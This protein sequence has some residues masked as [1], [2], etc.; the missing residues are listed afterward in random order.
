MPASPL[1]ICAVLLV[2]LLTAAPAAEPVPPDHAA[3]MAA[4]RKLFQEK[5]RP[6]L[7]A[8]CLKCHGGEKVRSGLNLSSRELL[9]KGGDNGPAVT[10]GKGQASRLVKLVA[11]QEEPHMPPKTPAPKEA[12][13]LLAK[14][15][16]LGAAYDKPLIESAPAG[17]RPLTVT[18][19]DRQYWAYR[20]LREPTP[21]PVT[22]AAWVRNPIDRF[23]LAR[24]EA[25]GIP[26]ARDADKRTLIRRVYFDLIGLPPTP[27]EVKAFVRDA[28]PN[29]YEKVV[30]Q[31]LASPRFG[32]RWARHWLD[33]ARY[34]E[35]HGFEHDYYRPYAYHYRDFVI[36]A[37]NADM[38]YDQ[39]M[40]WQIAGDELAPDDTLALAAT[41][42]LGA[43]VYPT[44]ITT[45]EAERVRYDA[46]DDMLATTGYAMLGLTVGCARCHDHKY[47]PIPTRD[48]YRMLS[49]F[50]TT[51]RSE[52]EV[53][54]GT[55]A[56]KKTQADFEAKLKPLT[57]ELKRYEKTALP[58]QLAAWVAEQKSKGAKLPKPSEANAALGLKALGDGKKTL[59]KLPKLQRDQLLKW[60]APQDAGWKSRDARIK[61]LEKQRPPSTKTKIQATTE[62][63][64]PMRHH[65]ALPSIPDFYP[66]TYFL[67]RGDVE[68]KDGVATQGFLQVL[69]RHPDGDKHWIAPKPA[70]AQ[71]SFRRTGLAKWLTDTTSGAGSLAARVMVNRLWHHHF[72]RGIVAT[73]NDFGFQGGHPTHPELL[74]WLAHDLASH[75]WHLKR[76]HKLMVM[77]RAYQLGASEESAK[78]DVENKLWSYR[79]RRRLEAEAIRDSLLAVGGLLDPTMYGPGT[80]DQGMRRRSIYFRVQRSQLIPMLQVFDWPDTLTSL[81]ARPTTVVAPQA[82]LFLNNPQV[83][84]C[85]EGFAAR[86][87]PTTTK[88]L[89][90]IVDRAYHIAFARPPSEEEAAA[91]VAFLK[92]RRE[93]KGGDLNAALVEYT[94]ALI[95]LNEFIYVD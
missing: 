78:H 85:A 42:F 3:K 21:P 83:R 37:F 20:T 54:L 71:T 10:P 81:G 66:T 43:G 60:F 53:D 41:G 74:E 45:R 4:A 65:T 35:S 15:I 32:E 58:E 22:D 17:K 19:Q 13:E 46:M 64:K 6:F 40:R 67:K 84:Q 25:A 28:S 9:L 89:P 90:A 62:G 34:A 24:M 2:G 31:L 11:R 86:L 72:G 16:D 47:D 57:V 12:V 73:L 92:A 68:Q 39:F 95:G 30:D 14:W 93:A 79:P 88:G 33:P 51:V 82:L 27:E 52:V 91:G 50:T 61:R 70:G 7:T 8:N 18:E 48:Y 77:S 87:K 76:V 59:D 1:P 75:G 94:H 55:P 49:A 80:L 44:Q 29:A 26:P 63:L 38:P 69:S 56:Q 23:L 5:V 36:K